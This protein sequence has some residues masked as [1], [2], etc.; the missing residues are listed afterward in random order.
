MTMEI[1]RLMVSSLDPHDLINPAQVDMASTGNALSH[2]DSGVFIPM[3]AGIHT[4]ALDSRLR[5][6]DII[7]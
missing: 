4:G 6:N 5:G 2:L 3:Q 7:R 1:I